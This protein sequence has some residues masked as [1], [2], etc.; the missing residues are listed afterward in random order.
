MS[1]QARKKRSFSGGRFGFLGFRCL[2]SRVIVSVAI[3]EWK[4]WI[5]KI[6]IPTLLHI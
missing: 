6:N 4:G 5:P 1:E 2:S 3:A